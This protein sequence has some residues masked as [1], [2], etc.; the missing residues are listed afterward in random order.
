[1]EKDDVEDIF[2]DFEH[3]VTGKE[4]SHSEKKD[5]HKHPELEFS[6]EEI[7]KNKYQDAEQ[8]LK[9]RYKKEKEVL[10]DK[11]AKEASKHG[12]T[13]AKSIPNYE[14]FAYIGVIAVLAVFIVIDLSFYHGADTGAERETI[15]AA[16]VNVQ[17]LE[18]VEEP[19]EEVEETIEGVVEEKKL[20]GKITF[21][22]DKIYTEVSDKDSELGYINK[23]VFTIDNGKD[24]VLT[25]ILH[26]FAYDSE[27]H[28]SWETR[29]RGKYTGIGIKPGDKQTGTI[30]LSLK[31][32]RNLDIEKNIRL[33]LNSTEEGF[34]TAINEKVTIE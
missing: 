29:S 15:T 20:S 34:I 2:E 16:A 26:V 1:M 27:L 6:E 23:I 14:K 11:K 7:L 30:D 5:I 19:V 4:P 25:P 9:D 3:K 32:F 33:T 8:S 22:I 24:E 10:E 21:M 31:T 28:E 17:E 18:E 13:P 12:F